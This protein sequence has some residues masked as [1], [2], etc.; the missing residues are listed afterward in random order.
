MINYNDRRFVPVSNSANGEVSPE[1]VFHYKQTD[2]IVT[3]SY[4]GG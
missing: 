4:A 3:Y 1:V 2:Q